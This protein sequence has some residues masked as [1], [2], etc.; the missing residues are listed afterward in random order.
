[1]Y[2]LLGKVTQLT[3]ATSQEGELYNL[4]GFALRWLMNHV[5]IAPFCMVLM[6][7]VSLST[8]GS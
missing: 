7:P 3:A 2:G 8:L 4:I 1:M 5:L 6:P